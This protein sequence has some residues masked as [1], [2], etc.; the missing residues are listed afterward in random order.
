MASRFCQSFIF[1]VLLVALVLTSGKWNK[2]L[3][4]HEKNDDIFFYSFWKNKN[5]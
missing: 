4:L 5:S 1:G 2:E 3:L